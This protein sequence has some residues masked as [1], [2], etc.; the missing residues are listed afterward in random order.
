MFL[1]DK[2]RAGRQIYEWC[3]SFCKEAYGMRSHSQSHRGRK[4]ENWTEVHEEPKGLLR[5]FI[6][7]KLKRM[8]FIL[9][10]YLLLEN[11]SS[12]TSLLTWRRPNGTV[13]SIQIRRG[14]L[15]SWVPSDWV[16]SR[17][18]IGVDFLINK[19]VSIFPGYLLG[20]H[21]VKFR[22]ILRGRLW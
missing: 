3:K 5:A 2:V 22:Y 14:L 17:S 18:R 1:H 15:P 6:F 9:L 4:R 13:I 11:A 7:P 19:P 8:L 21:A 12:F 10:S 16:R 20:E